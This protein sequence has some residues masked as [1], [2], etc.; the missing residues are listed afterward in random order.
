MLNNSDSSQLWLIMLQ[1]IKVRSILLGKIEMTESLPLLLENV[2][3]VILASICFKVMTVGKLWL[4]SNWLS[5]ICNV[6]ALIDSPSNIN[7]FLIKL[8]NLI[9]VLLSVI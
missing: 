5:T 8:A 1:V 2:Q 3:F 9:L 7:P 4:P 6:H